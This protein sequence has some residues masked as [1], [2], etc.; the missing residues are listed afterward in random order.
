MFEIENDK[1]R[2]EQ[3]SSESP[4][5]NSCFSLTRM[6]NLSNLL[7]PLNALKNGDSCRQSTGER[8][9]EELQAANRTDQ[10]AFCIEDAGIAAQTN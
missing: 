10:R 3:E 9:L 4:I 1:R 2:G 8:R 6:M 7:K 5:I